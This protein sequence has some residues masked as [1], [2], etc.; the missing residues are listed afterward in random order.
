[1][2]ERHFQITV[3]D[4]DLEWERDEGKIAAEAQLDGICI[5]RT[6]LPADAISPDE[7]VCAASPCP[8]P[9]G[10]FGQ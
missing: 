9:S 10:Y 8:E 5:V 3:T 7:S 4:D 1:M 2:V 6:S